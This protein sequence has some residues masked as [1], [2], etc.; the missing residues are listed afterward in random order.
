MEQKQGT[1][2]D[3]ADAMDKAAIEKAVETARKRSLWYRIAKALR[4]KLDVASG[5]WA[6]RLFRMNLAMHYEKQNL[7]MGLRADLEAM[8]QAQQ[9]DRAD[10]DK[11]RNE[12]ETFQNIAGWMR[13]YQGAPGEYTLVTTKEFHKL[14]RQ[15]SRKSRGG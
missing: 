15:R 4:K 11:L 8:Q 13:L 7:I 6:D 1:P 12:L 9:R 10:L 2:E 3:E 5:S 14:L